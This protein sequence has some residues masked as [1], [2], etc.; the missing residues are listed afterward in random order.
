MPARSSLQKFLRRA[1]R[2]SCPISKTP[3]AGM[4]QSDMT[5]GTCQHGSSRV[6]CRPM[7]AGFAV[8]VNAAQPR[9]II[10]PAGLHGR[11]LRTRRPQP[12]TRVDPAPSDRLTAGRTRN[13]QS[14]R[15]QSRE[16]SYSGRAAPDADRL[17]RPVRASARHVNR[18]TPNTAKP[19]TT[20]SATSSRARVEL[21]ARKRT[22]RIALA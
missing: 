17:L 5:F 20:A 13:T 2:L 16:T 8:T 15:P 12:S 22:Q 19:A 18:V 10:P 3:A 21:P 6:Q 4:S 1:S 7:E 14:D 11:S 9:R